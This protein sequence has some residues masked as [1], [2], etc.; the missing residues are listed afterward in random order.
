M[1]K[2]RQAGA[3]RR[4]RKKGALL[5]LSRPASPGASTSTSHSVSWLLLILASDGVLRERLRER[6]QR[7]GRLRLRHRASGRLSPAAGRPAGRHQPGGGKHHPKPP[8]QAGRLEKNATQKKR[9]RQAGGAG[10]QEGQLPASGKK[11][12]P[13]AKS[14]HE[15]SLNIAILVSNFGRRHQYPLQAKRNLPA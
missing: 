7:R 14:R 4:G 9:G 13:C 2:G 6:H 12:K 5:S 3:A 10:R 1:P 8:R 15:S 11:T